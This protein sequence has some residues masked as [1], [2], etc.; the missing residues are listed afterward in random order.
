M[1]T[2]PGS[3]AIETPHFTIYWYGIV[4]AIAFV[5]GLISATK[6]AKKMYNDPL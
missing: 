3:I 5:V 1:F 6:I 4:L 2:S